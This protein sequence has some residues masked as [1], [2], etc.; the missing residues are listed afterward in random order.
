M[1]K[2]PTPSRKSHNQ[3]EKK[4]RDRLNEQFERLLAALA[5]SSQEGEGLDEDGL[6]PLSKSAVLGLARR[7]LLTLEKENRMLVGEVE[8]LGSLLQRVG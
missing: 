3:V 4:Y 5:V 7:R 1:N 6:R 8:R 2:A